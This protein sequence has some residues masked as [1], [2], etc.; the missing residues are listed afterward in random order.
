MSTE[1]AARLVVDWVADDR[2]PPWR[3]LRGTAVLADLTGFTRLTERLTTTGAEG[4]E[5]LHRVVS[6][7]FATVLAGTI[8]LGGDIVGFA[9]D[10]AM[11]WFDEREHPDHVERAV[12]AAARMPRDLAGLP[13]SLTGGR[14]LQ[15]ST[16]VHTGE[17][18]AVLVGG[19][20]R[21][22]LWCG[23]AV[24]HLVRLES[25]AGAGQV[26]GS[27]EVAEL[28]PH[29]WRGRE[30]APGV[31]LRR[32]G[33]EPASRPAVARRAA[34]RAEGAA[35]SLAS[36][37][38]LDLL[39]AGVASGEHRPVSVGFVRLDGLDTL[40]EAHGVAH[41]HARVEQV[42]EAIGRA[43]AEHA[44]EWLDVDVGVDSVKFLL[45]AG[46]PRAIDRDE[47]R[48]VAALHDIVTGC[49]LTVAAGG[50]RGPVYAAPLG[51]TGRRTYTLLG[52]PVNVAAR[53]LALAETGEVV[54]ADGLAPGVRPD[55]LVALGAFQVKN[56]AAPVE[57]WRVL[58]VTPMRAV[59]SGR[60]TTGSLDLAGTVRPAESQAL[61]Q[62]WKRTQEG[63]RTSVL[64]VGEPGMGASD[65]LAE[66]VDLAGSHAVPIVADPVRRQ[67]PFA[68]IEAVLRELSTT[69]GRSP[70]PRATGG[71]SADIEHEEV[72][73]WL[74]S[75]AD[76]LAPVQA[77]RVPAAIEV[78]T[79]RAVHE[80]DPIT[81]ARR[82]RVVVA[83]LL[84]RV[85]PS[86]CLLAIGDADLLDDASRAVLELLVTSEDDR[87]LMVAASAVPGRAPVVP[88]RS[89]IAL[90]PVGDD[91]AAALV[92]ELAPQLREDQVRRI[93]AAAAGNPFVLAELA[94]RPA[95]GELPDSL[96]R[97]AAWLIDDLPVVT[98]ALVRDLSVIGRTIP[99][100][101]AADVLA[102]PD[103][104]DSASWEPAAS[105]LRPVDG[106]TIEFRHDVFRRV[107]YETLSFARR[108]HLHGRIADHLAH[109][110]GLDDAVLAHHLE[111]AGRVSEA[112][113]LA[114]RAGERAKA[115]GSVPEAVEL[116]D[117]AAE[118]ARAIAPEA[119]AI[120]VI[121]A[122][123][124][125]R[126]IGDLDG[127]DRCF[128][129][130]SPRVVDPSVAGRLC[131]LRADLALRLGQLRAA[132]RWA[133]RGLAATAGDP[134]GNA[135][136]RCHLLLDLA[137]RIDQ[138]GRHRE[139]LP[140]SSEALEQ[141]IASGSPVAEGL[142]HLHLEMAL[143]A[144]MDPRAI[145]HG[146]RAIDL[147]EEL[148]HDRYL[149]SAL[150]NAGLTAMYLGDWDLA[151]D[152]YERAIECAERSGQM[153][154][155]AETMA[156]VGF[157]RYRQGRLDEADDFARRA[158]RRFDPAGLPHRAA[159]GRLLRAFV[160][161]AE[162]RFR[163][164]DAFVDEARVA[165]ERVGDLA[166]VADCDVTRMNTRLLEARYDEVIAI[167]L[168]VAP[169]LGPVEPELVV[170]HGRLLG[171]AE[172]AL[173]RLGVGEGVERI[174]DVLG[175]ARSMQLR[176]EV[177]ECLRALVDV[178]DAGGPPVDAAERSERHEIAAALGIVGRATDQRADALR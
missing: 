110:L 76:R 29:A 43:V 78:V 171:S 103:L 94:R 164:A 70:A 42:V 47:E 69:L 155:S 111:R 116:L 104:V 107:A 178:A 84:E 141:A 174:R 26:V 35:R 25:A 170:T 48:L 137:A 66:L 10:A 23:P 163:E 145:D 125:R 60:S 63:R 55:G 120:H 162:G 44:V 92:L 86:P 17:F 8:D 79:G 51:V 105:V 98:R 13:A 62:M 140:L 134:V 148:G 81:S 99:L 54:I 6:T 124:A 112:Y 132:K 166:M 175:R 152:R 97:L 74:A 41:V 11:V 123:E 122:G 143:S 5:V 127:A 21:A 80:G 77:R 136:L 119:W 135:D 85:L 36:P 100:A 27:L 172:A 18:H 160:A 138:A 15:V 142:A 139:S 96:H 30:A 75:F 149:E 113:P 56:R 118:M 93:I 121:E 39:D 65:L 22:V 45:T 129:R 46:A 34:A 28:L 115:T 167:G 32:R 20:R 37:S 157:L 177:H 128:R 146:E 64:V 68:G 31:E 73:T 33:R 1:H 133:E 89:L 9:G 130:A 71:P 50:Q 12:A 24:S 14:R 2:A 154:T 58:Q 7:C 53:A 151:L 72:W 168:D 52:D 91:A 4:P 88:A 90:D 19:D 87:P 40:I 131:H 161:A 61:A 159:L 108:R 158:I 153:I 59:A 176:F 165:F 117:R 147:F 150:S 114:V 169:R 156:N 3:V 82:A 38:V 95:E 109:Q 101:V 57:L 126:W 83:S 49:D 16:G 106:S 67:V 144:L 102:H 173:G